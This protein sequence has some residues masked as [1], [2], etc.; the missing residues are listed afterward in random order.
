[1]LDTMYHAPGVGLAAPQ[2]G[3]SKRLFVADIGEG[4]FVMVNPQIVAT[5]GKLKFEEG[6]LS[7]PGRYWQIKRPAYAWAEGVDL[8]GNFI[9]F[10]G[11]DLLGRVLQHEIDHLDGTVLLAHL[12]PRARK[13]VLKELREEALGAER[14]Y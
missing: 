11:D 6:C 5:S 7:V 2:I 4:P 12:S 13:Q 14:S 10:E 9:A 3:I 8:D 1:M